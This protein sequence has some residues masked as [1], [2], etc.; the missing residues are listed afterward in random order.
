[1]QDTPVS[2]LE[3]LRREPAEPHWQRFVTLFTPLLARWATRLG[4]PS[5]DTE[6]VLQEAYTLLFRKLPDFHYDPSKSFRAWLWTV[7]H[8]E[9]IA[10]RKRQPRDLPLSIEQLECL[11][12]PDSVNEASAAEYR[13]YLL[14]RVLHVIQTDFPLQTWKIFWEVSV[15]GRGGVEVA[16]Q[17]GVTPNAVY[18]ARGRVLARLRQELADLDS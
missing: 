4:V 7:F 18:L 1:M 17:F 13:R 9:V 8:R 5:S 3:R 12:S 16:K 11:A 2:L 14:D 10:W 6:D 15:A